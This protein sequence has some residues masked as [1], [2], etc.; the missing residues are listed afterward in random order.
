MGNYWVVVRRMKSTGMRWHGE[1]CKICRVL[2]TA[3]ER[4]T[5]VHTYVNAGGL[6]QKNSFWITKSSVGQLV[7]LWWRKRNVNKRCGQW[8]TLAHRLRSWLSC[9][10]KIEPKERYYYKNEHL[11]AMM[12]KLTTKMELLLLCNKNAVWATLGF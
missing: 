11:V 4:S 1:W 6:C 12:N 9:I 8:K 2:Y 5:Y 7:G 10:Q 3:I